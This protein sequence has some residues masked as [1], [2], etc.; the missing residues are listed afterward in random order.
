M[1]LS[2]GADVGAA[3]GARVGAGVGAVVD[4]SAGWPATEV[5]RASLPDGPDSRGVAAGAIVMRAE[6]LTRS[7]TSAKYQKRGFIVGL[8][9]K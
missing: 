3:V 9:A 5:G 7:N 2:T 1:G 6:Q 8:H 4:A